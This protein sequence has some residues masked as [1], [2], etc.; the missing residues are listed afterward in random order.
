MTYRIT[1]GDTVFFAQAG[2]NLLQALRRAGFAPDAPCGG[3]GRCGKCRVEVNGAPQLAC[4]CSIDRDMTVV[5]PRQAAM[6]QVSA[7]G[8]GG[9]LLAAIDIG[10]TTLVCYLLDAGGKPLY[11][12]SAANPQISYGADVVSRIRLAMQGSREAM[13]QA[14]RRQLQKLL[15]EGCAGIGARMEDITAIAVVANPCMQQLF[16]GMEVE[17]LARIPFTPAVSNAVELPA[18]EYFPGCKGILRVAPA[19]AGYVGSDT[20]GCILASGLHE[21]K[22]TALL[23]DIGTNGEMVLCHGGRL[24][25][26]ATA[27]GPALEGANIRFGMRAA[28]GAIFRVTER[29][30]RVLGDT[31]AVGICGSGLVDAVALLL[32]KGLLNSRGKLLTDD[33]AYALTDRV[34]LTQEDIRQLQ[35]AK[36]AIA[37]GVCML[38]Q[39]AKI[40][41]EQIER[42]ILAGAFGSALDPE[43]VCRIGLLP[44]ELAGKLRSC[45]NLAG[46]GAKLLARSRETLALSQELARRI[47][48]VELSLEQGFPRSYSQNMRFRE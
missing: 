5:L 31:E 18:E 17:N 37:A 10:T 29:G 23:V 46:E 45:G 27:A 32:E 14:L 25:A 11:T 6:G 7:P 36:G 21:S 1:V 47:E 35:A 15:Q 38:A 20:L 24:L 42:V 41:L 12:C 3:M 16:L 40:S 22:D 8:A 26:C 13:T 2:E 9:S 4:R 30:C 44:R 43:S 39:A 34:Y 33:Q 19:V 28:E 48:V